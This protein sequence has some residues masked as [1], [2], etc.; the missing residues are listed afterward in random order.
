MNTLWT[1]SADSDSGHESPPTKK[2]TSSQQVSLPPAV[3]G[4]GSSSG[5]S[6]APSTPSTTAWPPSA[7][8]TRLE[9][10]LP[11]GWRKEGVKR[12]PGGKKPNKWDFAL[13]PPSNFV[14]KLWRP[15]QLGEYRAQNPDVQINSSV[16]N[17]LV[18]TGGRYIVVM[19]PVPKLIIP[20]LITGPPDVGAITP[21]QPYSPPVK[22]GSRRLSQ[23]ASRHDAADNMID[24]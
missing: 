10:E 22:L 11:Y 13:L 14:K 23:T 24:I 1:D 15:S 3:L 7:G 21:V 8:V 16:T 17:F 18:P 9:I 4:A 6:Q 19:D 2:K 20:K 12:P 5:T